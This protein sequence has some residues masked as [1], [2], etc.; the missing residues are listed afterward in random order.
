MSFCDHQDFLP[1]GWPEL[2]GHDFRGRDWTCLTCGV[3][4]VRMT[5]P[6]LGAPVAA[7]EPDW[8]TLNRRIAGH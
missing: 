3:A 4:F 7:T 2:A 1:D 5:A 6:C 8:L